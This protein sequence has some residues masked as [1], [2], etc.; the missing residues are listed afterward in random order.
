MLLRDS[1]AG[2][3]SQAVPRA[4]RKSL[5]HTPGQFLLPSRDESEISLPQGNLSE[6]QDWVTHTPRPRHQ[7]SV[8]RA[9]RPFPLWHFSVLSDD[10]LLICAFPTSHPR[11]P[12]RLAVY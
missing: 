6:P 1:L 8:L 7:L 10:L 12:Q 5:S 2:P 4:A 3:P 11:Y 9:P